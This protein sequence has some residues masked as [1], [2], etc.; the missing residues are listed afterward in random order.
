MKVFFYSHTLRP[1][2]AEK[3]CALIAADIK[4]RY[5]YESVVILNWGDGAKPEYIQYLN[6]VGVEL[7][8]LPRNPVRRLLKLYLIFRANRDA[9]LFNYLTY[10]DFVGALV[11]RLAGLERVVGGI[12]TDRLF[13]VKFIA[14]KISHRWLSK[15]TICNSYK[16][17]EFFIARNFEKARMVIMPSAIA[18]VPN[19]RVVSDG[20]R[21]GGCIDCVCIN[22]ICVG[23]FVP[24]KNYIAWVDVIREVCNKRGN[25]RACI[26]GYGALEKDIRAY[27]SRRGLSD[28]I[29]ILP[30]DSTDIGEILNAAD[31]YLS[32]SI[33]EGTSNTILEAM[34]ASLP[35]VTTNVG[36]NS[37]MIEDGCSGYV[38]ETKDIPGLTESLLMLIDNP[39]LRHKFG[40]RAKEIVMSKYSLEK[41]SADYDNLIKS[42]Q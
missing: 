2:G 27:I 1:G 17:Y 23:R 31:I 42:L 32:T 28:V 37:I 7:V 30:G 22:I 8:V 29:S 9:V 34:G 16:A 6:E 36:D 40:M 4:K 10:P 35:V 41:I 12:E 19:D 18:I 11:A 20:T 38:R 15:K 26:I 33:R 21:S 3:Q 5:G 39:D 13:G 14:E 25:V 24:A